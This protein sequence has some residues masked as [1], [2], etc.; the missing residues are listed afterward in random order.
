M[1]R[2]VTQEMLEAY[3]AGEHDPADQARIEQHLRSSPADA[4]I[5]RRLR[6]IVRTLRTDA[7]GPSRALIDAAIRL[8]RPRSPGLVERLLSNLKT[9][10]A[11]LVHDSR[12]T[13]ALA[14]FR[15]VQE[16]V[17]VAYS[18]ESA[19]IEMRCEPVAA[20]GVETWRVI[21]Q[22][23][24]ADGIPGSAVLQFAATE[25]DAELVEA[26]VDPAGMFSADLKGGCYDVVLRI[27]DRAVVIPEL[28]L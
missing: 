1:T 15:S 8:R 2:P 24:L 5:I 25:D 12:A 6:T 28:E 22:V 27:G 3:A 11:A 26:P 14:G 17:E 23:T 10:L 4:A 9:T 20:A 18:A 19:E 16:I 21:G 13:P 7:E